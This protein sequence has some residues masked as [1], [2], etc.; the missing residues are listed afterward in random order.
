M[1]VSPRDRLAR[2]RPHARRQVHVDFPCWMVER[3]DAEAGRLGVTRQAL[4]KL[5]IAERL[6]DGEGR[7]P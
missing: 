5:W 6:G 1:T 7:R 3:L 2:P 4:I